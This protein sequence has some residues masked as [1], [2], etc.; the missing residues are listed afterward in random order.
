MEW[1]G[2]LEGKSTEEIG[3]YFDTIYDDF[4]ALRDHIS[5]YQ[6]AI[7]TGMFSKYQLI[8]EQFSK[9]FTEQKEQ[10][11]PKKKFAFTRKAKKAKVETKVEP[12]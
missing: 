11:M 10:A 2:P 9:T 8:L 5:N 6:Y 1:A 12:K 3:Q 4:V 7:P